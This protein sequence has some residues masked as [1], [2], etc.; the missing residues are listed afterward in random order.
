MHTAWKFPRFRK[1]GYLCKRRRLPTQYFNAAFKYTYILTFAEFL[2]N[3]AQMIFFFINYNKVWQV[4]LF[5]S[6]V[7]FYNWCLSDLNSFG[8]IDSD[9]FL[10]AFL[11]FYINRVFTFTQY[12]YGVIASTHYW[13]GVFAILQY[14]YCTQYAYCVDKRRRLHK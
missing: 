3:S 14:L 12:T 13:Y 8:L 1:I 9:V 7:Y 4:H 6:I 5:S 11:R 10:K 2:T